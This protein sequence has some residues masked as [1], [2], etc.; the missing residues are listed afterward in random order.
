MTPTVGWT[1]VAVLVA[2]MA[3][4]VA[5]T[6]RWRVHAFL[7][8]TGAAF[9][10]GLAAFALNGAPPLVDGRSVAGAP[11]DGLLTVMAK[12]FGGTLTSIGLVILLGTIIGYVLEKTGGA[13]VLAE[14]LLRAVGRRRAPLAIGLA[15]YAIGIPVFCDSGFIVLA[16]LA[17]AVAADAGFPVS[18]MATSLSMGLYSTHVMVPPTP[19]PLAAAGSLGADVGRVMGL[20]LLVAL[21]AALAGVAFAMRAGRRLAPA[22][23]VV[24]GPVGAPAAPAMPPPSAARAWLPILIPVALI[25]IASVAA[26][27]SHPFGARAAGVLA[28]AGHPIVALTV[29]VAL[30]LRCVTRWEAGLLDTWI[31][32]AVKDAALI[33]VITGAGGA[34]G[35]V[36]RATGLGDFLGATL[37]RHPMGLLLPFLVAATIKTAQGSS[38]VAIVTS[39]GILGPLLPGLGWTGPTARALAVL[40]VG[41]GSMVVSH[42]NDSYFWVVGQFSGMDAGTTWRTHTA[43]SLVSGLTA[44]AVLCG[45]WAWLGP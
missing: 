4:I 21:P 9:V 2:V 8:L 44:L 3:G 11:A 34:L 35:A 19:G 13:F 17:R 29:G 40:A 5:C 25:A 39:A 28:F 22:P 27:P 23:A 37:A 24:P 7:A 41:A 26:L 1:L 16:A 38:T 20:G 42:A 18:T 36:I 10:F 14:T 33:L 31:G 12:G 45:L 43:A 15:G 32:A 6:V 30:A